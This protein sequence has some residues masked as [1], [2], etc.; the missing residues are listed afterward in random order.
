MKLVLDTSI[1]IDHLRG[2][3]K[4]QHILDEISE[5]SE[6]FVSSI[7]FFELF[8]GQSSKKPQTAAKI[9]NLVKNF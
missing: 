9:F 1:L 5:E 7:V 8:S 4:W 3:K 6:L 2:G